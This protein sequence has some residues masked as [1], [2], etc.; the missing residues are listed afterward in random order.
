[1]PR[2][3]AIAAAVVKKRRRVSDAPLRMTAIGPPPSK[4]WGGS[5]RRRLTGTR[6]LCDS[7]VKASQI[8]A[9][10]FKHVVAPACRK[11]PTTECGIED[12]RRRTDISPRIRGGQMVA[13][14]GGMFPRRSAANFACLAGKLNSMLQSHSEY[15]VS[16]V[17]N[18]ST[19]GT[20]SVND[21][22]FGSHE[23]HGREEVVQASSDRGF[24]YVFAGFSALVAA[25]SFYQGGT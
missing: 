19:R 5:C 11:E 3:A 24:G 23:L 20:N 14:N 7:H 9:M 2:A 6:H 8:A 16:G 13:K 12:A 10:R 15:A 21:K 1:M 25:L 4:H 17:S 18:A 22:Y